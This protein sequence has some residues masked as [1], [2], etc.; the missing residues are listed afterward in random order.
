[1][2][3]VADRRR[4]PF[5]FQIAIDFFIMNCPN[6]HMSILYCILRMGYFIFDHQNIC[7]WIFPIFNYFF[8]ISSSRQ[9]SHTQSDGMPLKRFLEDSCVIISQSLKIQLPFPH[10]ELDDE[11]VC[12]WDCKW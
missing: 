3:M 2:K 8:C 6:T 1:M 4:R 9:Q 12:R 7:Y 10:A 5:R 11:D